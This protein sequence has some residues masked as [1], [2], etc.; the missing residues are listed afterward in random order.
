VTPLQAL[1]LLAA[2]LAGAAIGA[3]WAGRRRSASAALATSSPDHLDL[4]S[5]LAEAFDRIDDGIALFDAAGRL[6]RCNPRFRERVAPDRQQPWQGLGRGQLLE[7]LAERL[8]RAEGGPALWAAATLG[9]L[10][11]GAV[12]TETLKDGR[13]V[14]LELWTRDG[15]ELALAV[16]DVTDRHQREAALAAA[17][18]RGQAILEAIADAV[19]IVDE[20]G[21]IERFNAAA[22]TMFGWRRD[23]ILG[24]DVGLLM[25]EAMREEHAGHVARLAG[26]DGRPRAE[27]RALTALRR[28]GGEF[29]VDIA[30]GTLDIGWSGIER[31][32]RRRRGFIGTIRDLTRQRELEQ[33]LRRA[34]KLEAIGTLAG[35]IAHDFNNLLAIVLGYAN[36]S[37]SDLAAG[38]SE[39]DDN[40]QAIEQAAMRGKDLVTQILSFARGGQSDRRP[41][42]LVPLAKEVV[43]GLRT[44]VPETVRLTTRLPERPAMVAA[45]AAQMHQVLMN[46]CRNAVQAIGERAGEV[47]V[48]IEPA[49]LDQSAA[50]RTGLAMGDYVRL[51]VRDTGQGMDASTRERLFEP[52]FTTK[53]VGTGTGLGL[54]VVHGVVRDHGGAIEVDSRPGQGAAFDV[55]LPAHRGAG[56]TA[57]TQTEVEARGSEHLLLVEDEPAIR[58][59]AERVLVRLGYS[60]SS[61]GLASEALSILR[62]AEPKIDLLICDAVGPELS[63]EALVEA[64]RRIRP[65]LRAVL[66][67]GGAGTPDAERARALGIGAVV[68]KPMIASSLGPAVRATLDGKSA[69]DRDGV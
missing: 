21:R 56:G 10:H 9:K 47:T 48:T 45:D 26:R 46:L 25:P 40:L 52:F 69:I 39:L 4:A 62:H 63:G 43:K 23:D 24:R 61:A 50:V 30:L 66:C 20:R 27:P 28:D 29:P 6:A 57:E 14:A 12:V 55:F 1:A 38:Q 7:L 65:D 31:R 44:T 51:S 33:R 18:E 11:G 17:Q 42:D 59:L 64:A 8:E 60:V 37:R 36:L 68:L 3:L 35:G 32:A 41:F 49:A 16:R 15:R 67:T 2:A 22:E 53:P 58:R 5:A 54:A 34:Q 19:V 13:L